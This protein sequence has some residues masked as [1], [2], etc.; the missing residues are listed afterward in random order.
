MRKCLILCGKVVA[1]FL[2]IGLLLELSF[3]FYV[4]EF[5]EPEFAALNP[6]QLNE[7]ASR[8]NILFFGDSFT[9]NAGSY[10]GKLRNE[11]PF[12]LINSAVSGTGVMEASFM[13]TSR[14]AKYDPY[15]VVYQVY[16]GNDL[17][18]IRHR[19]TGDVP[20][21][22]RLYHGISDHIRVLKF[23]N[24]RFGQVKAGWVDDL[25]TPTAQS[26]LDFSPELY[27]N[28][29]KLIFQAEPLHLE[30]VLELKNGREAEARILIEG[31][32]KI[33]NQLDEKSRLVLLLIPHCAEVNST[34]H[35]RMEA[36]GSRSKKRM[37]DQFYSLLESELADVEVLNVRDHFQTQD[38]IGNR[39]Y[40]ENDPH[41]ND[42]G[43]SVLADFLKEYLQKHSTE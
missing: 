37:N 38:S 43:H 27:S 20:F 8:P 19:S 6:V 39:L 7:D 2:V 32:G 13:A 40:Y 34:Y 12:N 31:L 5:Y 26:E 4:I 42:N 36:I 30:N 17:L 28:R 16:T 24:Y 21:L 3:R 15:I 1:V 10:V 11:L 29:Q 35:E 33:R 9:A 23:L 14:L 25:H 18:D 41:L 22:R